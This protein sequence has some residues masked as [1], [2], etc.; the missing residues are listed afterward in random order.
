MGEHDRMVTLLVLVAAARLL[1]ATVEAA[2]NAAADGEVGGL[3]VSAGASTL[4]AG[5]AVSVVV[6]PMLWLSM[7]DHLLAGYAGGL[8]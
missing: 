1:V 7:Y 2:W 3:V 5:V 4:I 8:R 6:A